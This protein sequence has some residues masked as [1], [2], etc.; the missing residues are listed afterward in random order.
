MPLRNLELAWSQKELRK[1]E[2]EEQNKIYRK[3]LF[4]FMLKV[5]R[6]KG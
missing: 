1:C 4:F 3:M 6:R 5:P 2:G